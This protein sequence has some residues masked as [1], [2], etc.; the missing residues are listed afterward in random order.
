MCAHIAWSFRRYR[1]NEISYMSWLIYIGGDG[2]R[3]PNLIGYIALNKHFHNCMELDSGS[4]SYLPTKGMG[5][6]LELGCKS[7]SGNVAKSSDKQI[8][9]WLNISIP[10]IF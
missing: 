2:T 5:S 3:C 1:A 6:E 9:L 8:L 10:I 4:E 7:V